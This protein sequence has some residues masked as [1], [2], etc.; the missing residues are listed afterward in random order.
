M[1]KK[2]DLSFSDWFPWFTGVSFIA[3]VILLGGGTLLFGQAFALLFIGI[4]LLISPPLY[5]LSRTLNLCFTAFFIWIALSFLPLPDFLSSD[6]KHLLRDAFQFD[7]ASS[8]TPQPRLSLDWA[9][10][11]L[12]CGSW[13]YLC[14]SWTTGHRIRRALYWTICVVT[15][16]LAGGVIVGELMGWMYPLTEASILKIKSAYHFTYFP[17]RNQTSLVM[18]MGAVIAYGLFVEALKNHRMVSLIASLLLTLVHV[19]CLAFIASRAGVLLGFMGIG[20]LSLRYLRSPITRNYSFA[21]LG[22]FSLL[23][24]GFMVSGTQSSQRVLALIFD[25]DLL[26]GYRSLIYQD[27]LD[28]IADFAFAGVG[29]GNF[30]YVISHYRFLSIAD[31]TVIHP[32]SDWLWLAAETGLVGFCLAIAITATL[33]SKLKWHFWSHKG[34]TLRVTGTVVL[35]LFFL[36]TLFDVSAHR[37]GTFALAVF[38]YGLARDRAEILVFHP[39]VRWLWRG[40]GCVLIGFGILWA[41]AAYTGT[42]NHHSL[43]ESALDNSSELLKDQDYT[44]LEVNLEQ[45]RNWLPLHWKTQFFSGI[46]TLRE[47]RSPELANAFFKR[48]VFQNKTNESVALSVGSLLIRIDFQ[49]AY[50]YFRD[51]IALSPEAKKAATL[52]EMLQAVNAHPNSQTFLVNQLWEDFP[53]YRLAILRQIRG[54]LQQELFRSLA[55]DILY[56]HRMPH[57]EQ[58]ALFAL[59]LE[60]G[61]GALVEKLLKE[62]RSLYNTHWHIRAMILAQDQQ[63]AQATELMEIKV[64]RP[65]L[66]KLPMRDLEVLRSKLKQNPDDLV[67]ALILLQDAIENKHWDTILELYSILKTIKGHPNSIHYWYALAAR[68][69]GRYSES[70]N[71][72]QHYSMLEGF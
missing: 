63:F 72:W 60:S 34:E 64:P 53:Q 68:R 62:D 55:Q 36:H 61:N 38:I 57:R 35:C 24:L 4:C 50:P 2:S 37:F 65:S 52:G 45:A 6:W 54:E 13:L 19:V 33:A 3:I 59:M 8:L 26:G 5:G 25:F 7:I 69:T 23:L 58:Y 18:A 20:I 70:W 49:R 21:A 71:A 40:I 14:L 43:V 28:L 46:Q 48:A 44:T 42:P 39:S 27:T 66:S 10:L 22:I 67:A 11:Y 12:A 29:L 51:A 16:L 17:N 15:A 31:R 32:E 47:T 56:I 9:M 30:E 41:H 1:N